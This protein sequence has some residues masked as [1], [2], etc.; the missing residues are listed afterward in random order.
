MYLDWC[1]CGWMAALLLL[2]G[3]GGG[4]VEEKVDGGNGRVGK[5]DGERERVENGLLSS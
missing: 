4:R 3:E 2:D 1:R 5:R